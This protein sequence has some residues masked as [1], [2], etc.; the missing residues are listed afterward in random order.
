M[1]GISPGRTVIAREEVVWRVQY[2]ASNP[3]EPV[4]L[5]D[6]YRFGHAD[7]VI[8]PPPV[9]R[10]HAAIVSREARAKEFVRRMAEAMAPVPEPAMPGPTG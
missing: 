5:Y 7:T 1:P 4:T 8:R 10:G 3:A 2:V 6:S 9:P